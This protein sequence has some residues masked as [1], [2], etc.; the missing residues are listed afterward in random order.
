MILLTD[1]E[2]DLVA[3]GL[4]M[5]QQGI[6]NGVQSGAIG[7]GTAVNANN[8]LTSN[9][10]SGVNAVASQGFNIQGSAIQQIAF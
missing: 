5:T 9:G 8:G 6:G 10:T 4:T 1:T 3:G 7:G 2:L